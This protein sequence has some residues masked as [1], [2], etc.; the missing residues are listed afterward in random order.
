MYALLFATVMFFQQA[1]TFSGT[2]GD[3]SIDI[4]RIET[5]AIVDGD[6]SDPVWQQ[7]ARLTDFSQYQPVDGRPASDPTEVFVYY[8]PDAIFFGIR[9]GELPGDLVCATDRP[10]ALIL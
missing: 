2:A 5:E 4:P 1:A 3:T 6:L 7:A 8:A 10:V 9:A